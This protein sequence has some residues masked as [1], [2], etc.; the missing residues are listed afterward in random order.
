MYIEANADTFVISE[1]FTVSGFHS[2]FV[3]FDT[4][5]TL[6][7][8]RQIQLALS[9]RCK[10]IWFY[11]HLGS[12]RKLTHAKS[13]KFNPSDTVPLT[14]KYS[15][16]KNICSVFYLLHFL[17]GEG[18]RKVFAQ[19]VYFSIFSPQ[20]CY[21]KNTKRKFVSILRVTINSCKTFCAGSFSK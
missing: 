3:Q 4:P 20:F 16:D 5:L 9:V 6:S 19:I 11:S 15:N 18:G 17:H 10:S 13:F 14:R 1:K 7:N 12:Q 8:I 2:S 21:V